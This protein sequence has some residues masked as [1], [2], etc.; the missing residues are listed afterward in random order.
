MTQTR[1]NARL[2]KLT[3]FV[4]LLVLPM[5]AR[6]MEAD[7]CIM[8]TTSITEDGGMSHFRVDAPHDLGDGFITYHLEVSAIEG[9]S[10]ATLFEH[11]ATGRSIQ[12]T[13]RRGGWE[14]TY[15]A[16]VDP[17][18][19]V[20]EAIASPATFSLEEVVDLLRSQ[21]IEAETRSSEFEECGCAV[22]YPELVGDRRPWRR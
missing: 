4:G 2:L 17:A 18:E 11:C 14:P 8:S 6:A 10:T 3:A 16:P 20:R 7:Q 1:C 12:A 5:A 13:I 21:G 9:S 22:F 19:L 15:L